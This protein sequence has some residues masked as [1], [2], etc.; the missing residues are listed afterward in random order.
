MTRPAEAAFQP[1]DLWGQRSWYGQEVVGESHYVKEIRSLFDGE[2]GA[3]GDELYLTA[4]LIPEPDNNH[5]PNAVSVRINGTRV[6]YL[7]REDAGRYAGVLSALMERGM[8]PQVQARVWGGVRTDYEYDRRGKERERST[9]V[10]SVSLDL[11]EPHLLVPANRPPDRPYAM[12]PFGN[13]IQVTGEEDHMAD[14]A[15]LLSP[16]AECWIHITLHETV[17]RLPRSTRTVVE[18]SG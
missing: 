7:P 2:P 11:S 6:G 8:L 10:G 9:F 16:E 1:F 14:L 12:L 13:A 3:V 17:E 4:Q 5:D 18:V 15:P